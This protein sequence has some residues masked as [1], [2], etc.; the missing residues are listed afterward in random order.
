MIVFRS[1]RAS[2]STPSSWTHRRGICANLSRRGAARLRPA[3]GT[4]FARAV[5]GEADAVAPNRGA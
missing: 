2:V 1:E 5:A 3:G 4:G